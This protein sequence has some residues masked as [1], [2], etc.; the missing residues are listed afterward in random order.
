MAGM[1]GMAGM[2][3]A[4]L[5]LHPAGKRPPPRTTLNGEARSPRHGF[6]A[7]VEENPERLCR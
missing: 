6:L 7:H 3:K 5:H 1:A 4:T 2:A